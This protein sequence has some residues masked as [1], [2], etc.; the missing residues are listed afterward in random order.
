VKRGR[1][2]AGGRAGAAAVAALALGLSMAAC[3]AT[4]PASIMGQQTLRIG[5]KADQPG[6]GLRLPDGG[7]AGF[8]VDVARYVAAKLGVHPDHITFVPVTSATRETALENG[9]VDMVFATYSIT[10]QRETKVTFGGPYYVAHQD[11]MVRAGDTAIHSVHDLKGKRLCA[12]TGSNSWKRVT[13]QLNIAAILA[14]AASYS[15][16]VAMLTDGR[17]DAVST[18]DLILAGFAARAGPAVRI[19]NAPFSYERYGIGIRKGD[20]SG[21]EAVNRAVSQM[22]LDGTAAALL[23]KWFGRTRLQLDTHVPQFEGCE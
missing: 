3:S 1:A 13:Q 20:L 9:S 4:G 22:Y 19:V 6:L 8:D 16:C 15:S 10:P 11:T 7:F 21:C 23:Q 17:T 5:V 2:K 12:V 18:D 14:P